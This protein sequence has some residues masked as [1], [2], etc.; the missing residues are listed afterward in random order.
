MIFIQRGELNNDPLDLIEADVIARSIIELGRPGA[1]VGSNTLSIFNCT[2]VFQI[3]GNAC[4]SEG[5]AAD[6]LG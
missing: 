4:S 5:M 6:R 3:G 1:L 2:S